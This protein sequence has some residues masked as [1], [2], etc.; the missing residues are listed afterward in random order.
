[1][2]GERVSWREH[3]EF[4][5][6]GRVWRDRGT[7]WERFTGWVYS[8]PLRFFMCAFAVIAALTLCAGW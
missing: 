5:G 1:V 4:E 8:Y 6:S 2:A 7:P 3:D